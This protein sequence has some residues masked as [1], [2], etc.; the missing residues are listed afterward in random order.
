MKKGV[1]GA[2]VGLLAATLVSGI[3]VGQKDEQ[4]TA[5]FATLGEVMVQAT[6]V[7]NT[8]LIGTSSGIPIIEVSLSYGVSVADLDLASHAGATELEQ[9]VNG[10][11]QAACK[12]LGRQY[13]DSKPKDAECA[14][15]AAAKAMVKVHQLVAAAVKKS[16]K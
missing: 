2:A 11:A 8:K 3:A 12:E 15:A 13:P 6:R 16:A 5:G 10:A 4:P 9:R 7:V 14:K 1:M